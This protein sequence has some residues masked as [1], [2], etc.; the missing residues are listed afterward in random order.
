MRPRKP[1]RATVVKASTGGAFSSGWTRVRP[2]RSRS[3]LSSFCTCETPVSNKPAS[4][5]RRIFLTRGL[6]RSEIRNPKVETRPVLR[7]RGKHN[8]RLE[9]VSGEDD[10]HAVDADTAEGVKKSE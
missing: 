2:R 10:N 3:R 6:M 1:P 5:R 8:D 7:S 9:Y 4:S